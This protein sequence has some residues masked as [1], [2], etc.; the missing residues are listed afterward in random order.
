MNRRKFLGSALALAG[1]TAV[2]SRMGFTAIPKMKVRRTAI[3]S[4]SARTRPLT[5]ATAS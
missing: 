5:R 4:R 2:A 3:T 1:T